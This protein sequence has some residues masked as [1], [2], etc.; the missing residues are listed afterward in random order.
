MA[1]VVSGDS[2]ENSDDSTES[3]SSEQ[4]IPFKKKRLKRQLK[5]P[6]TES[7]GFPPK[8]KRK[9]P[10]VASLL[11]T[12]GLSQHQTEASNSA[13][14][15]A[16]HHGKHRRYAHEK[17]NW[18]V[19]IY[20]PIGNELRPLFDALFAVIDGQCKGNGSKTQLHRMDELHVSLCICQAIRTHQISEF[21]DCVTDAIQKLQQ[22]PFDATLNTFKCFANLT[23][24]RHFAALLVEHGVEQVNGLIDAVNAVM[25]NWGLF[26]DGENA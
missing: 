20:L 12:H 24:Q 3:S 16:S 2:S 4:Q 1:E 23:N 9:L 17:G 14:L 15:S 13:T 10:S 25:Q 5:S 21:V 8:K 22:Q 26:F 7:L 11:A 6:R 18:S 19:H